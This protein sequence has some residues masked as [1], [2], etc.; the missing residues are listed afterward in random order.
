MATTPTAVT[1]INDIPILLKGQIH[2]V[3]FKYGPNPVQVRSSFYFFIITSH[4]IATVLDLV[5]APQILSSPSC[6]LRSLQF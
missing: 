5:L 4:L 6:S 1:A 3:L 2:G